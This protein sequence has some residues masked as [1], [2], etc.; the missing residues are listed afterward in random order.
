MFGQRLKISNTWQS[1]NFGERR[2][3]L[4]PNHLILHYTGME[5]AQAALERLV[6]PKS[7]VS[8]H[9][10]VEESGD[11][12][13]LVD[14]EKR[15]WHAGVAH[16]G[17]VGDINSASIG[18]EIV[19]PGDMPFPSIQMEAVM[20][21]SRD[22]IKRH[23]ISPAHVLGHSD[24]AP[25]R[26]ID[27][28]VYFPWQ[29]FADKG[30]GLWPNPTDDDFVRAENMAGN[31]AKIASLLHDFGYNPKVALSVLVPTFHLHFA[32][33]KYSEG[34]PEAMS[35]QDIAALISLIRQKN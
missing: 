4:R 31:E 34:E 25:G 12:Y 15:A 16:W 14:E 18:I 3:G 17:G 19:N 6:D 1:P 30:L 33:E 21:L 5:T 8:A 13:G 7:D 20:V 26:K 22:I 23:K 28:G 27:P 24:I 2:N 29:K 9:Y 11:I 32:P 10:V 35:F